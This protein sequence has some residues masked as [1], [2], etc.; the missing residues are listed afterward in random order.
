MGISNGDKS[1]DNECLGQ[2]EKEFRSKSR[3]FSNEEFCIIAIV[4]SLFQQMKDQVW[5]TKIVSFHLN[6]IPIKF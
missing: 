2:S 5:I 6:T 4:L 1:L 3:G